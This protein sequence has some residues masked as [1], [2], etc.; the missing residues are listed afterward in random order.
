MRR[1]SLAI[2]LHSHMPYVE[3]FGTWPFGEE[4]LWE[5][6][7]S[8]YLPLLEVLRGQ[9]VTLGLTPVLCDQLETLTGD[10]GER[11]T[12]FL[13]DIRA[14]IHDED[15]RGLEE[16][17]EPG[18]AGEVRRAAGDYAAADEAFTELRGDVL[19]ALKNLP[20]VELWTS[21]ATHAVL[22]LVATEPGRQLQIGAGIAAHERRFGDWSGGFW[23]PECAYEPGLERELA[24]LG[25][26]C[27]CVDQTDAR[28]LGSLDQLEPVAT[29]AGPV[30][31]PIDWQT[32]ELIWGPD[33]YPGDAGYRD[34]HGRTIHDLKPWNNGGGAYDHNRALELAA[35]H[36][37]QFVDH[38]GRRLDAYRAERGRHGLLCCALDTELIGHWWYEGPAF[39]GEVL[40][41]SP[42]SGVELVTLPH[43]LDTLEP[44]AERRLE[45]S[46]W[47]K[48]KDLSTWDSPRVAEL[49][50]A[51]RAAELKTVAAAA[52]ATKGPAL[53]RAARELLALQASDWAFIDAYELAADYPRQRVDGHLAG[54]HAALAALA[55]SRSVPEPELRNLAP[56][57]DLSPLVAP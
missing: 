9:P 39:L 8:V 53:E 26:R 10:P 12:T 48:G 31:V 47:G 13:R 18:L 51:A 52:R 22:P 49:A 3:G 46:S 33:G 25:T 14:L 55:D 16:G 17:G 43:A 45:P 6:L 37:R 50:F 20:G 23:L 30:A 21:A 11:F 24:E 7:A 44:V 42:E 56:E 27:F 32:V 29:G 41:L 57:L 2:V 15:A 5:A 4:W 54:L 40:R 28:G 35:Q 34:Y 19:T 38:V 36:A 1:G